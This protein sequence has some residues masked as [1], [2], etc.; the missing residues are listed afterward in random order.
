MADSISLNT[1]LVLRHAEIEKISE[2]LLLLNKTDYLHE[3]NR[4]IALLPDERARST[5]VKSLSVADVARDHNLLRGRRWP[6]V[7]IVDA[8]LE[9]ALLSPLLAVVRDLH[10]DRVLHIENS[11]DWKL[12]NSL[13][14]GFYQLDTIENFNVYGFDIQ[15]YKLT[16]SWL[17]SRHWANPE[18]WDKHRW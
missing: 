3:I 8:Q 1:E 15:T 16:P 14:L 9:E 2:V 4:A 7:C 10:S 6:L 11:T 13:A 18:L 17:N 12:A 5:R